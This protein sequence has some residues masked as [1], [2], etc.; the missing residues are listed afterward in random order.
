[1]DRLRVRALAPAPLSF[2][3]DATNSARCRS[4]IFAPAR[5]FDNSVSKKSRHAARDRRPSNRLKN[6]AYQ[7]NEDSLALVVLGYR[8]FIPYPVQTV[9]AWN[10]LFCG[11]YPLDSSC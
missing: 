4:L 3:P 8:D 9:V 10:C 1:M 5:R 2:A 6:G 7:E 11:L